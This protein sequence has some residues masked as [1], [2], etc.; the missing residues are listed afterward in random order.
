MSRRLFGK[1]FFE[2]VISSVI[3]GAIIFSILWM[4]IEVSLPKLGY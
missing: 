3:I 1:K 4:F 2:V